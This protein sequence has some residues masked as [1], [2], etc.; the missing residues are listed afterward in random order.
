[1]ARANI[2]PV[3]SA[4]LAGTA[5]TFQA[6]TSNTDSVIPAP[7]RVLLVNNASASS[8]TLTLRTNF[9]VHSLVVPDRTVTIAAGKIEAI[10]MT[11][12]ASE[13]L[14][15]DGSFWLDYSA[16]ATVSAAYVSVA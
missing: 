7:G 13:H 8:V 9:Q 15:G 5:L 1:M 16:T 10:S 11:P 12:T 4:A 3:Q 2:Y 6:V 14:Q